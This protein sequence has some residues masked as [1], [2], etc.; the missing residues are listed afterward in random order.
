MMVGGLSVMP[1]MASPVCGQWRAEHVAIR[2]NNTREVVPEAGVGG[3]AP[4]VFV[5][6]T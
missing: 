5:S 6:K 4:C 2:R 3:G 1:F